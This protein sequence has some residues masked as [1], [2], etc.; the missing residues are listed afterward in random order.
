VLSVDLGAMPL[1]MDAP[2]FESLLPTDGRV[3]TIDVR[4]AALAFA[5]ATTAEVAGEILLIG[6]DESHLLRQEEVGKALAAAR[7]LVDAMPGS[8]PGDPDSDD[9]WYVTDWMDTTR[10]QQALRFQR[11]PWPD[12][13]AEMRAAAGWTRYPMRLASPLVRQFLKRRAAYR[14]SPGRYADPWGAIRAELGEPRPAG[15][16]SSGPRA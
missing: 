11:H 2:F 4:D 3:H 7:G 8:R 14:D 13:L 10:A 1:S 12:M 15:W 16:G 9:D 6:G 5:R